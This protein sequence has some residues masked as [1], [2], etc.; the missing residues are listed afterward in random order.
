MN[1]CTLTLEK[2]ELFNVI[3]IA[4]TG[5]RAQGPEG[6]V[7]QTWRRLSTAKCRLQAAVNNGV[8]SAAFSSVCWGEENKEAAL[9]LWPAGGACSSCRSSALPRPVVIAPRQPRAA[10][11]VS[12]ARKW[13]APNA[14]EG[15]APPPPP[16]GFPR[17]DSIN[18]RPAGYTHGHD[19][20][21]RH[22]NAGVWTY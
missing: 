18:S 4:L 12:P 16:A 7:R 1:E 15:R 5:Q 22:W 11:R 14:Y 17:P 19:A 13:T 2:K 21:A 3:S 8:R 20:C 10:V 9:M 6:V